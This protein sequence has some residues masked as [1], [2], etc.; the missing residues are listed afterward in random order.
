MKT[1]TPTVGTTQAEA[2][3]LA[4]TAAAIAARRD[5]TSLRA[6]VQ[7]IAATQKVALSLRQIVYTPRG[8]R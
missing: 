8:N 7:R 3:V 1:T 2:D 6:I 5:S 4:A